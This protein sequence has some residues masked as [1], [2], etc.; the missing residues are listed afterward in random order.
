LASH[1]M[2]VAAACHRDGSAPVARIRATATTP[3]RDIPY[4]TIAHD[5][6]PAVQNARHLQI[7]TRCWEIGLLHEALR[8]LDQTGQLNNIPQTE[9]SPA[10]LKTFKNR[11]DLYKPGSIIWA[12]H[13]FGGAT[14]IQF[15]K[16]IF[17]HDQY[18]SDSTSQISLFK[19]PSDHSLVSQ[20]TPDSRLILLDPWLFVITFDSTKWLVEKPMPCHAPNGPGGSAILSILSQRFY[21]WHDHLAW[22]IKFFSS[23]PNDDSALSSK[24]TDAAF[25]RIFYLVKSA[26]HS[27]SD[28]GFIF[29]WITKK[30]FNA[31][32]PERLLRLN[33][34][35]CLQF[36]REAGH[37][38][39]D[40]QV[41]VDVDKYESRPDSEIFSLDAGIRG[42]INV[43]VEEQKTLFKEVKDADTVDKAIATRPAG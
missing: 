15:L 31:E 22:S 25:S 32:E 42:W 24:D 18:P 40:S 23:S 38:I 20:I 2:V 14:M 41:E 7:Q 4:K 36:I 3:G 8:T 39:A 9:G 11:L 17:Y 34:R 37:Q 29:P 13:S 1:G 28:F 33:V 21:V 6:S 35:A 5:K 30:F 26:H 27:Q 12:G 10:T 43:G 19:V 16:S